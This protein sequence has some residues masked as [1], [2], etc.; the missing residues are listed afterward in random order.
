MATP[1]IKT[2]METAELLIFEIDRA[3]KDIKEK[4]ENKQSDRVIS[5]HIWMEGYISKIIKEKMPPF[6]DAVMKARSGH[7]G[8]FSS[9]TN[10]DIIIRHCIEIEKLF[11]NII[12]MYKMRTTP[13]D[14]KL[15]W[16]YSVPKINENM[17]HL[18]NRFGILKGQLSRKQFEYEEESWF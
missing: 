8:N 7:L 1:I 14:I 3:V 17:M 2:P 12:L 11:D 5:N 6:R 10:F 9:A 16:Q 18:K 13:Y 4:F 15:R